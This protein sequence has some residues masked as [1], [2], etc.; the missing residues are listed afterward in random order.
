MRKRREGNGVADIHI[1]STHS[2][3]T[4]DIP[5]ILEYVQQET[6]LDVI[7]ITDHNEIAGACEARE[8]TAKDSYRFEVVVGMEISTLE[9][10]LLA[11]FLESPVPKFLPLAETIDAI[12]AQGGICIVPHPMCWL[13]RSISQNSMDEIAMRKGE[14]VYLDGLEVVNPTIAGRI[15]NG[16]PK[17]LNREHYRLAETGSSDAHFLLQIGSGYTLFEGLTAADL[18]QGLLNKTTRAAAGIKVDLQKIGYGKIT[19]HLFKHTVIMPLLRLCQGF[20]A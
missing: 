17:E 20:F 1:H 3:G 4:A 2:D 14:D 5:D 11:L 12:H 8:L 18:R 13:L 9:G 15:T 19:K 10:H 6:K 16:R 7:A